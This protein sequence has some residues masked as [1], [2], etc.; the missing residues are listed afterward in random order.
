MNHCYKQPALDD[1]NIWCFKP[2]QTYSFLSECWWWLVYNTIPMKWTVW[3][4]GDFI[5]LSIWNRWLFKN[6]KKEARKKDEKSPTRPIHHYGQIKNKPTVQ[7]EMI[8]TRT[9][10]EMLLAFHRFLCLLLLLLLV[11]I[12]QPDLENKNNLRCEV[13]GTHAT[14]TEWHSHWNCPQRAQ[15]SMQQNQEKWTHIWAIV[16]LFYITGILI[17]RMCIC[18]EPIRCSCFFFART[19]T[20]TSYVF[21]LSRSISWYLSIRPSISHCDVVLC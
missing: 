3:M 13:F 11:Y 5:H 18:D 4:T 6:E 2:I 21:P 8:H 15:E 14:S 10:Y 19:H 17:V 7:W 16:H 9:S 20:R 1:S 12:S